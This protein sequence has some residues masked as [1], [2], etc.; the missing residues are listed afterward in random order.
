[1]DFQP[2]RDWR[3]IGVKDLWSRLELSR[4]MK[5]GSLNTGGLGLT[6]PQTLNSGINYL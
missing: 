4:A 3:D 2:G 1:M 5:Q 6:R